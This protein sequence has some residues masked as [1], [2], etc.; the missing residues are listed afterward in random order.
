[1]CNAIGN[2]FDVRPASETTVAGAEGLVAF[3]KGTEIPVFSFV[4]P[5]G[6]ECSICPTRAIRAD[7][8][9]TSG[10]FIWCRFY[11]TACP[12]FAT[13]SKQADPE[14]AFMADLWKELA[15]NHVLLVPGGYY[16]PW[17][18]ENKTTTFARGEEQDIGYFR[19]AYS[20]TTKEEMETGIERMTKVLM[21][22]WGL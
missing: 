19:L 1:M 7:L 18:G 3:A 21:G 2:S 22:A 5:T 15:E 6:G 17:Q 9:D 11:L 14:Q 13:Y 4:P 10:M 8:C 12:R 16:S 20:M